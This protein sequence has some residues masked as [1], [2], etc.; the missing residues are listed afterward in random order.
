MRPTIRL[1][2]ITALRDRLF[3]S[4]Y[5][6]LGSALAVAA[7]MASGAMIESGEMSLV[8][9]AGT[10]RVVLIFGLIVFVAF[11]VE[12]MFDTREIEAILARNLSRTEFVFS[13]W[14]GL[15]VM[16][17]MLVI[18]VFAVVLYF[19]IS[20]SGAAYWVVSM[21]GEILIV[22]AATLFAALTFERAVP[23]VLATAG[24]YALSRMMSFL[25][26]IA[27]FGKQSGVNR[28]LNPYID[29]VS[30][31]L[32]RLDLFSQTRWLVYGI[33][34]TDLIWVIAAQS[35]VYPPLLLLAAAYDLQ[36][37]HF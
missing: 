1:V 37:K 34:T 33:E 13:Y 28:V 20:A 14:L 36:R 35:L 26:G 16:A 32:P 11:H 18:P 10:T 24:F 25:T 5:V 12:R 4:L 30:F 2:L 17:L 15:A 29:A 3:L 23:T 8:Y 7:F 9:M 27:A 22:L 19:Q 6:L 31:A 21:I